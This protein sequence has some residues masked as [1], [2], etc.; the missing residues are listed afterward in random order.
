MLTTCVLLVAGVGA[1]AQKVSFSGTLYQ[2]RSDRDHPTPIPNLRVF[3]LEP[4]SG[5]WTGPVL[6][7]SYG[8]FAF[9]DLQAGRYVLKIYRSA[10]T[11]SLVWQQEAA[12]PGQLPPIVLR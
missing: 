12:V 5:K 4:S 9:Y 8:R 11:R 3:L 7:D 10:D 1:L 2:Y 6:T